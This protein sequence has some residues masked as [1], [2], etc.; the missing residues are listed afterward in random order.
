MSFLKALL[1]G[2]EREV[3]KLRRIVVDINGLESQ[4]E[5][6]S[7]EELSAKSDEFREKLAPAIERLDEAK[8]GRRQAKDPVEQAERDAA[9]KAAFVELEAELNKIAPEAFAV[10]REAAKRTV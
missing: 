1:D 5:A 6:L 7:D 9:V 2:N 4:L 3:Q 10:V 8:E